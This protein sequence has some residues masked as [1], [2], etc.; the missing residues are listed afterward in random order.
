MSWVLIGLLLAGA[1]G[2][3][4]GWLLHRRRGPALPDVLQATFGA[5][6]CVEV[7]ALT[8]P[9]QYGVLEPIAVALVGAWVSVG[10]AHMT[11]A[12]IRRLGSG[13]RSGEA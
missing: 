8:G 10:V 5:A 9:L 3:A 6:L 12:L 1:S 13:N 7:Y 2:W 11:A 4:A